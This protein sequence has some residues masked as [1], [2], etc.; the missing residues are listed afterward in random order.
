MQPT[1]QPPYQYPPMQPPP[2]PAKTPGKASA[3]LTAKRAVTLPNWAWIV[4]VLV[5]L[6]TFFTAFT[7]GSSSDTT[8]ST[9]GG[10]TTAQTT[11]NNKPATTVAPKA[12][13]T[14]T[15]TPVLTTLQAFSGS[16]IKNTAYFT[17]PAEWQ[18]KWTCN[19]ASFGGS[20]NLIVSLYGSDG[21][22]V[23]LPV[24]VL[25]QAGVTGDTTLEHDQAGK[26][27]LN[28]NSEGA[29]TIDIQVLK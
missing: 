1:D 28:V 15:H 12:T 29:W 11:G 10:T 16:G 22:L 14:P 5:F 9:T 17:V 13:A 25:C 3:F 23:D 27:Y 18:L 24:N 4:I 19:P 8:S 6:G 7:K 21:S 2:P 20:Y 26:F